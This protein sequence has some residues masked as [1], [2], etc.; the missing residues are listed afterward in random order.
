MIPPPAFRA[1]RLIDFSGS[2]AG[3][4]GISGHLLTAG[5]RI[6]RPG[7][8]RYLDRDVSEF[9]ITPERGAA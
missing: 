2:I 1:D 4:E 9:N 7:R 6:P 5:L 8:S 3:M